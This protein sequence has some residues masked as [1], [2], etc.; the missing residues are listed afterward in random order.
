MS[1]IPPKMQDWTPAGKHALLQLCE[2]DIKAKINLA[3]TVVFHPK[4]VNETYDNALSLRCR[5]IWYK[6]LFE[7]LRLVYSYLC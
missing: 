2:C 5:D 1:V 4:R 3:P 6:A 7:D